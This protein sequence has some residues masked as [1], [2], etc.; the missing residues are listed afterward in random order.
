MK[1]SYKKMSNEIDLLKSEQNFMKSKILNIEEI[2]I[3][4]KNI[5]KN[6]NILNTLKTPIIEEKILEN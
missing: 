3:N 4:I 2:N 5:Y 1:E 6:L